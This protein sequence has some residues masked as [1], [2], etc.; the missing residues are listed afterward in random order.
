[1]SIENKIKE[2]YGKLSPGQKKVADYLLE[3]KYEYGMSTATQISNQVNVSETTV[4]RLSYA[5]GFE[6]FSDMQ[7]YLQNEFLERENYQ[8][9]DT[10]NIRSTDENADLFES[11]IDKDIEILK[12]VKSTINL[13]DLDRAID[14]L[15]GADEVKIAGYRASFSAAH[16]FYLKLSMMRDNVTLISSENISNSAPKYLMLDEDK[17]TVFFLLSFPSYVTETINI[18]NIA[19]KQNKKIISVT[20]RLTSSVGRISDI[21]LLTDVNAR[22]E[23]LASVSPVHSLLNLISV[24][25]ERKYKKTVE[26]RIKKVYEFYSENGIFLE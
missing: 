6:R 26:E 5:L 15:I 3:N 23:N 17:E 4:I 22:S 2:T 11:T 14:M 1:M 24:A 10:K 20:D 16:W 21:S 13:E 12:K 7:K 18:A 8:P 25:I 9:F 19:K